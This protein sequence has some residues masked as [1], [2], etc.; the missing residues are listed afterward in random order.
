MNRARPHSSRW[1]SF[2]SIFGLALIYAAPAFTVLGVT[3]LFLTVGTIEGEVR[4]KEFSKSIA[5]SVSQPGVSGAVLGDR[6]RGEPQFGPFAVINKVD[7]ASP[8]IFTAMTQS[9]PNLLE[10]NVVRTE[11]VR[12]RFYK[13]KLYNAVP[14]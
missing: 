9:L 10:L 1:K 14:V 13:I 3:D 2:A 7:S 12:P 8:P 11:L 5:T 4:D 6:A